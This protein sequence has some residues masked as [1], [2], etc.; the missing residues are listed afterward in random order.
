[1]RR[2]DPHMNSPDTDPSDHI[3]FTLQLPSIR[4]LIHKHKKRPQ[5]SLPKCKFFPKVE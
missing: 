2:F 3:L 1:M 5:Y 4:P